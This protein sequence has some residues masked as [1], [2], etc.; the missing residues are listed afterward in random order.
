MLATNAARAA[1]ASANRAA[2]TWGAREW[3]GA[4]VTHY[5]HTQHAASNNRCRHSCSRTWPSVCAPCI[6]FSASTEK[7]SGTTCIRPARAA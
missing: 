6:F 1:L 7:A 5:I 2:K 4:H 3:G